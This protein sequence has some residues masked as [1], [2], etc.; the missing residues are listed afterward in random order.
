MC[1]TVK[2]FWR[3]ID[4]I[5]ADERPNAKALPKRRSNFFLVNKRKIS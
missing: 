2:C 3:A 1:G 4:K 5:S